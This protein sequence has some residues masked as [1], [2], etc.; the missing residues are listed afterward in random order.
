MVWNDGYIIDFQD[1]DDKMN[2]A[3][4]IGKQATNNYWAKLSFPIFIGPSS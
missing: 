4:L 1:I 2:R 3:Y